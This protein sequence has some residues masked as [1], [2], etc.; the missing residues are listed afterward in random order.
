MQDEI[1]PAHNTIL[2]TARKRTSSTIQLTKKIWLYLDHHL[3]T[4]VW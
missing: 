4:V 3:N 2:R 1:Q